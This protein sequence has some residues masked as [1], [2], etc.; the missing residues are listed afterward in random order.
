MGKLERRCAASWSRFCPGYEIILWNETNSPVHDNDYVK[1]AYQMK[2]WAFVSD[3]VPL[4]LLS[5]YGGIY[6]DTD[7]AAE[8]VGSVYRSGRFFRL[9][10]P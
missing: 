7:V 3:Y 8:I 5:E 1:Q 6:L 4:K 2:K 10:K 9:R